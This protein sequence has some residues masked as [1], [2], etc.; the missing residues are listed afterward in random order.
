MSKNLA[1]NEIPKSR[2]LISCAPLGSWHPSICLPLWS[3]IWLRVFWCRAGFFDNDVFS[4]WWGIVRLAN[5][6]LR[7]KVRGIRLR[8]GGIAPHTLS[9]FS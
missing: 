8:R 7:L 3:L 6:S 9:F 1:R 5:I 4:G 2:E